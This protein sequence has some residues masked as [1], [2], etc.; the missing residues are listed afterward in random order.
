MKEQTEKLQP[1]RVGKPVLFRD[2]S[3]KLPFSVAAYLAQQAHLDFGW[4]SSIKLADKQGRSP[5]TRTHAE[6]RRW[7][8]PFTAIPLAIFIHSERD[9]ILIEIETLESAAAPAPVSSYSLHH[10]KA[11]TC[12][13]DRNSYK[14]QGASLRYPPLRLTIAS[15]RP[16]IKY[17]RPDRVTTH[18]FSCF[19]ELLFFAG[20]LTSLWHTIVARPLW[21]LFLLS[22]IWVCL[23]KLTAQWFLYSKYKPT[24]IRTAVTFLMFLLYDLITS[25]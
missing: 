7:Y 4:R 17:Y 5:V 16:G 22:P 12:V 6:Y 10:L 24:L 9:A 3:K 19:F 14:K 20:G 1:I 21:P 25:L 11:G 13:S 15:R 18:I 8:W 2:N 23:L